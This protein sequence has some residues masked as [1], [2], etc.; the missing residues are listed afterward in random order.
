MNNIHNKVFTCPK[1]GN[2][3]LYPI[4]GN[5][6]NLGIDY[7]EICICDECAAELWS[8]PQY[9]NTVKD[10]YLYQNSAWRKDRA[11]EKYGYYPVISW[12]VK[13]N[14]IIINIRSQF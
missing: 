5:E 11:I 6:D 2:R 1:C 10:E 14:N 13:D 4:N 3:T 8:K 7:H 12:T 9:D